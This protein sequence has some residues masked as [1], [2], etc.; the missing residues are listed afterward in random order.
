[1]PDQRI[2]I[3]LYVF[4]I[5][6]SVTIREKFMSLL[7]P[8]F[9][10][11]HGEERQHSHQ[12]IIKVKITVYPS[13]LLHDWVIHV[14][15][16][17][18]NKCS[19]DWNKDYKMNSFIKRILIDPVRQIRIKRHTCTLQVCAWPHQCSYR[20]DPGQKNIFNRFTLSLVNE[21]LINIQYR[22]NVWTPFKT[23]YIVH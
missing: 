3:W 13:S 6:Q 22:S 10:R 19:S 1:M 8:A 11:G 9:E 14:T 17:V 4:Y 16:L 21:N 15:I 2:L 20:N 7:W 12:H 5:T 23:Y 18:H